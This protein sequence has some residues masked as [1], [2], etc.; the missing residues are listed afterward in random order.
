MAQDQPKEL[1]R[2]TVWREKIKYG[3]REAQSLMAKK[4]RI[5]EEYLDQLFQFKLEISSS[6]ETR[7]EGN[8]FI[9]KVTD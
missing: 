2:N 1:Y 7:L 8:Y 4:D 6:E 9:G 3:K 5:V